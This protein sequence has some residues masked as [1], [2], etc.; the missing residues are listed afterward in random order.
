MKS[1]LRAARA[2]RAGG[3]FGA[4]V[5]VLLFAVGVFAQGSSGRILGIVTDQS[6]G[7][8]AGATVTVVDTQRGVARTLS[9]DDAGEYNAP[10]L[11][12]GTYTIRVEAKGF[13][14]L[15]RP[16]VVLQVGQ[17]IRVDLT[18]QPGDQ[19][20]SV[21]VTE[22][23]P[24][25]ETTSATLG[26]TINN[27]E[28]VDMPLNGR[29][30]QSLMTLRPGVTVYPGAGPETQSA[31]G[32]RPDE[33][34][35]MVEGVI[36]SDFNYSQ[37]IVNSASGFTDMALIMPVDAIQEFN[38]EE[39]PKA[40]Y[41]WKPGAVVNVGIKSGTNALHG[42]AYAFG[43]D[44]SLDARNLF[45]PAPNPILPTQ[46]EQ[47]GGV[48][49]GPI[50]K[51]KLFFF[52][53]Y[54]GLRSLVGNIYS[55]NIPETAGQPT[56]DPQNS[57]VDAIQALQA[58]N[59]PRSP[60]S[61]KL[62]GCTEPTPT[63]ATCTGGLYSGASPNMTSFDST[64][65][66][67]N[68][69][70][71][72]VAKIDYSINDK[73]R[74]SGMF[75]TGYYSAPGNDHGYVNQAFESTES[76][77]GLTTVINWTSFINSRVSNEA[78][79]GLNRFMEE[80]INND[81]NIP[82]NGSGLT[83]GSGY[84]INTGVTDVGGLPVIGIQGFAGLGSAN[85]ALKERGPDP[86]YDFQDNVSY[87]WNKHSFKFG[88]EYSHIE[89][90][91][92]FGAEQ[93]GEIDFFGGA[94]N[95]TSTPLEDFFAGNPSRGILL[96]GNS[97]R[98]MRWMST[99]AFAQDD[100][101]ITPKFTLNLG[102][103]YEYKSPIHEINNL[104]GNFDPNL[105]MVQ[106]GQSSVGNSIY[107]PDHKDFSPRVGF[108][109]DV[110]GNGK[111]VVRGGAS[112]I[113]STFVAAIFL[114]QGAQNSGAVAAS[115][116]PTGACTT[117][118]TTPPTPCPQTFGGTIQ[119]AA[120]TLP[121]S[122]P[123]SLNWNGVVFPTGAGI[124]CTPANPCDLQAVDPNLKTPYVVNFSFGV[125]HAFTSNLALEVGYVGN[126]GQDLLGLRDINQ[127]A[128]N[129][130]PT[131]CDS[132]VSRPYFAQFPYLEY[133]NQISNYAR[134]NYDSLQATLTERVTHGVSF[135]AGYTYAHGLDTVSLNRNG[136]IPQNSLNPGAEYANSDFDIRHRFTF[137][138]SYDIPGKKGYGQLLEGWKLN[139]IVTLETGI[140]WIV[141]DFSN[142][143]S[144]TN[145]FSDR[146]DF[147]GNPSDFTSG[148]SSI[149]Y[150]SGFFS[151]G[152]PTCSQQSGVDG[153]VTTPANSQAMIANCLV[154]AP[155]PNTLQA[156]GCYAKGNSV[157][158]P[159]TAG[160][161]GTM[162]RNIF[163]DGGFKN[164]DFSVFKNFTFK[165]RINAQ[166]RVEFF[167]ILNHPNVANPYGSGN[168]FF[169]GID[170]SAPATFGCGCTTPDVAAGNPIIGSGSARDVQLGLKIGF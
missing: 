31:N 39:N 141:N 41:G 27:S 93:R 79:F 137:T 19:T 30:Y 86:F 96:V 82:P 122:G 151:A 32:V 104:F 14:T 18:V 67:T 38:L 83:G 66:T 120:I 105:G 156:G 21:T 100:W 97:V 70:N 160:T 119:F 94:T 170:P 81:S 26:G 144:G 42:S 49:G 99:A 125:Q 9:T 4:I 64:F 46:L 36:N 148:S 101:R 95:A 164:L 152:G 134:S 123:G 102:L 155:D 163:R 7:S 116:V 3:V 138:A 110:M 77:H 47:F 108:A 5:C 75:W 72:G 124:S 61:E 126:H 92:R 51:D 149:P 143:F 135:I 65:P 68:E 146:W 130:D 60:V 53:G 29:N 6:G 8:V 90:D 57:M 111:T 161:F 139:G 78:R 37:P 158:T 166:F 103:R 87:L 52:A 106:Q 84:A 28:I 114:S 76:L 50:K 113:Y 88:A 159:P 2:C 89:A 118:P 153:S 15:E 24:L 56:P 142:N 63:T 44:Q 127:C 107:K 98:T 16:N 117:P 150:C 48:V 145:D 25:V 165:E 74:L 140:P 11:I 13:K 128:P 136:L 162:G 154:H 43:R 20:Q 132:G 80:R 121:G 54:E 1:V 23:L 12:P 109:W 85:N 115:A 45:N 22:A 10:T 112:V 131:V 168:T 34:V 59:I 91:N 55:E 62:L 40:E 167:N 71:N 73:N 133:I 35:W 33:S 157:M 147:F 129:P 58:V 69:S 169:G 17:E